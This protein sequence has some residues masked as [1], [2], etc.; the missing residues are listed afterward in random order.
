MISLCSALWK[1]CNKAE[2]CPPS[3]VYYVHVFYGLEKGC[4]NEKWVELVRNRVHWQALIL[5]TLGSWY[6]HHSVGMFGSG[7]KLSEWL[8]TNQQC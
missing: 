5:G 3:L 6:S 1:E 8:E 7:S 4:E 2:G